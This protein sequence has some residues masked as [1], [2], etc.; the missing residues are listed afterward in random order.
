MKRHSPPRSRT[1]PPPVGVAAGRW[2]EPNGDRRQV[3]QSKQT[4]YHHEGAHLSMQR[5]QRPEGALAALG[6]SARRRASAK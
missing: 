4:S 3:N 2:L 6:P 1:D 5:V